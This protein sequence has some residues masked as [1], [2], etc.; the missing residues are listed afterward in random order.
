[1]NSSDLPPLYTQAPTER[2]SSRA[3]DYA[4]HRPTYPPEAIAQILS[5]LGDP[6][7]LIAADIGAGTG[8]SARLLADQGVQVKAIEP[9]AAMRAA[10]APHP[11]VEFRA[12]TAEQTG[13][14]AQSIDLVL[15]CQSFHWFNQPVALAEF[16]R[17][18]KPSRRVALIWNDRDQTDPFTQ[19]H[20]QTI[21]QFS[22]PQVY[23][24]KL[25]KAP[26]TLANSP[27]FTHFRS[28]VFRHRQLLDRAGL[29]G[30]ALSASYAP[31][32]ETA[33]PLIAGL[34]QLYDR[35]ADSMG[36]VSLA[37]S[38]YVYLANSIS[39]TY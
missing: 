11:L 15:C 14:A 32:P 29:I 21:H 3:E 24:N 31:S 37:Y 13:L 20:G 27:H 26:D 23:D 10:A 34:N 36:Q 5:D 28:Q 8:I 22:E 39:A 4:K 9:N 16:H 17:I 30:L 7:Q 19:A 12:G 25:R 38:T 33:Q 18:L 35:W 2:F 1:M 6:T